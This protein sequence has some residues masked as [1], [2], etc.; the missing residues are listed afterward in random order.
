MS[1]RPPVSSCPHCRRA[2]ATRPQ[3]VNS[4]RQNNLARPTQHPNNNGPNNNWP[5]NRRAANLRPPI[6]LTNQALLA[7]QDLR[8]WQMLSS[9]HPKTVRRS[10]QCHPIPHNQRYNQPQ[11]RQKHRLPPHRLPPHRPPQ[12]RQ[13]LRGQLHLAK[14]HRAAPPRRPTLRWKRARTGN[15]GPE[16]QHRLRHQHRP[17]GSN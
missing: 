17:I 4:R 11:R 9:L 6:L 3:P 2:M 8:M 13:P 15:P 5:N 7:K 16:H 14:A 10:R 1:S 12:R